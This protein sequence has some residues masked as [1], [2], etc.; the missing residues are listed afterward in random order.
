ML[1]IVKTAFKGSPVQAIITMIDAN[2]TNK[3]V[4]TVNPN[5]NL[6][7]FIGLLL[8]QISYLNYQTLY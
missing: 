7:V 2:N 3:M 6:N 1:L 4:I 5:F 8:Y